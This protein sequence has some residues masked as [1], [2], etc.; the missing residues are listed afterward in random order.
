MA[1]YINLAS[2]LLTL[3]QGRNQLRCG[4]GFFQHHHAR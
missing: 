3:Q 2:G 1:D 4:I